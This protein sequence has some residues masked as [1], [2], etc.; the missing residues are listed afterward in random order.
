MDLIY[1]NTLSVLAKRKQVIVV[2]FYMPYVTFGVMSCSGCV[3]IS[4][5]SK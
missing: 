5:S 4:Q 3:V 2:P 1:L